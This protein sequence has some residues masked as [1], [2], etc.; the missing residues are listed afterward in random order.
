MFKRVKVLEFEKGLLFR[1]GRYLR[2]LE[3][4]VHWV[5]GEVTLIDLRRRQ[6]MVE[7]GPVLTRDLVPVG[8]LLTI[9]YRVTDPEA[10]LLQ[11]HKYGAH[12]DYDAV[13]AIHRSLST[14]AMA[15]L[16]A[17]HLRLEHQ[18][19]DRLALEVASYGVR[20]EDVAIVQVRFPRAIR[21]KLKRQE[22]PGPS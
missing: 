10:A 2:L 4:G 3:P 20:V 13:A 9:R 11:V 12:L 6:T 8:V 5:R 14:V 7:A 21:R 1:D 16:A 18:I 22:V 17:E 15:D 19:H